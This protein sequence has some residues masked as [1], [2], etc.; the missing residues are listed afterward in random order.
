MRRLSYVLLVAAMVSTLVTPTAAVAADWTPLREVGDHALAV[1]LD[2]ET[3]ALI[4]IGGPDEATIHD[5]RVVA[6][7]EGPRTEVMTVE[8]AEDCRPVEAVTSLGNLAVAVECRQTT[9]F[10]DPPTRLVELVWT[11]DDGWVWRVQSEGALASLDYSPQGQYVLFATNSRYGRPHHLTSYHADLGWRDLRRPELGLGGDDLVA[12]VD[13][14]GNVVTLRGSGFEDEPGYWFGGRMRIETYSDARGRW[15]VRH[16]LADPDGGIAPGRIDVADGRIV[17]AAVQSRS[18][19]KLDGRAE[20]VL[21]LSGTP[22]DPRSWSPSRWSRD[23]REV[24]AGIT[25]ASAGVATWLTVGDRRSVRPWLATW[26]PTRRQPSVTR[27]G[28]ASALDES[29]VPGDTLDLSVAAD[30]HGV[31]AR[32]AQQR[33]AETAT[34]TATSFD[35]GARGRLREPSDAVWTQP[36][37][38]TVAVTAGTDAASITIGRM[39]S[40]FLASPLV[41]YAVLPWA[42]ARGRLSAVR[43]SG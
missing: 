21:L 27:L 10:E 32:T 23:V 9:G 37:G 39:T 30:G 4:S 24:S 26:A 16:R 43:G 29:V 15:T 5:Q 3:V 8:G 1:A 31:V 28:G 40:Y 12:A 22:R 38:T 6:G 13:D 17:A 7:S 42:G 19:G 35:L 36:A 34:V 18:T 20:R 11:G 2:N 33:G 25:Q 41:Q 14:S